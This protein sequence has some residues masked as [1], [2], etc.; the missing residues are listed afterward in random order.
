MAKLIQIAAALALLSTIP[1]TGA[2][3]QFSEPAAFA[4]QHPDRDVLNGGELTPEARAAAGLENARGAWATVRG[5]D[6]VSRH[7]AHARPRRHR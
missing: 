7:D 1:S 5:N 2:L 6:T 3:A 4:S